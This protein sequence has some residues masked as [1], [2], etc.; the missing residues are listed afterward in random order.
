MFG[1]SGLL[2]I[3]NYISKSE[4]RR[5]IE[6]IDVQP[7]RTDLSRRTQHYGYIYDYRAKRIDHSMQIGE[8]PAWLQRIAV[9]LQ[10]DGLMP[11]APDQCIVNE[12][13]PGQGITDHIDC[14]P[15][16]GG[17]IISLSLAA[18]VVMELKRDDQK[19]SLLLEPRS[20]LLLRGEARYQWTHGIARRKRDTVDNLTFERKRRLSATFRKVIVSH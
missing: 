4:H 20:L 8:L 2:Y 19:I 11:E 5:L 3:P 14:T 15:C 12:Y 10:D 18:P 7:W 1:V 9:R 13:K 16:F 6:T 17:V